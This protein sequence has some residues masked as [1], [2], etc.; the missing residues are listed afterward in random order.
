MPPKKVSPVVRNCRGKIS[1]FQKSIQSSLDS[2]QEL[3]KK[4]A[5]SPE[6]ISK[7]SAV[8][9]YLESDVKAY[10]DACVK[11]ASILD[12]STVESSDEAE[13]DALLEFLFEAREV[14][15]KV[16]F[17]TQALP[18]QTSPDS[19]PSESERLTAE[20]CCQMKDLLSIHKD[21][22]MHTRSLLDQQM[23][24]SAQT[25]HRSTVNLP[26]LTIP[27]F[28]G[29]ILK[30]AEFQDM[31]KSSVEDHHG[32]SDVQKF[33]YLREH[34]SGVAYETIA[35]LSVTESN[36]KIALGLLVERFGDKQVQ[37]NA[38][39]ISL[40]DLPPSSNKTT[41]L[42]KFYDAVETHL[43]SLTA[44]DEDV[45]QI[46]YVS[47]ITSKISR[48]TMAQLE[49]QKGTGPWSVTNLRSKLQAYISAQEAAE[50]HS[51]NQVMPEKAP[52]PRA[53][54]LQSNPA[55][56]S[57]LLTTESRSAANPSP[58]SVQCAFCQ[59]P[60]YSDECNKY[61][62][63]D[64]RKP[65]VGNRCFRCLR[66][67]HTVHT[68]R[69]NKPCFYCRR[70]DHHSSLCPSKFSSRVRPEAKPFQPSPAVNALAGEDK[71]VVMQ[72]AVVQVIS[73]DNP[74][75]TTSARILFDTGSCRS[76][77][78]QSLQA[79]AKLQ[80]L[81]QDSIALA[82]FGSTSR[83]TTNYPRVEVNI[84]Q[85]D[86]T[87][88][89]ISANVIP[90]ITAPIR[91]VS[92]NTC[93][94]PSLRQLP[95][96]EPLDSTSDR[97]EIDILIGLDHYYKIIG[98][99]RISFP[100]GLQ[101]LHSSV[102][103]VC[104][105]T[106]DA[107]PISPVQ[108]RNTALVV[109]PHRPS[110][111]GLD[112]ERFW[113]VED[114]GIS[115]SNEQNEDRLAYD[116]FLQSI[117]F[118][119]NRY[120]V[121]WPW[122]EPHR[123]LENNYS[124]AFGRLKSLMK[125][126]LRDPSTLTK[127]NNVLEEQQSLGIL[128][129]VNS[130]T[131][132]MSR[133]HYLPHHCVVKPSNNTTKVRIVYDASA[134]VSK[135]S[136]S[137]NDCLYA[138]PTLLP[139]LCGIL[140][141]FRL[142]PI[143]ICSD[144]EKAFLQLTL[145][146]QDRDV[147]RFLWLKNINQPVTVD[148]LQTFRFCRVPFGI[149]SS[150]FLL[151]ATLKHHLTSEKTADAD[152]VLQNTYVDNIIL[153]KASVYDAVAHYRSA[154]SILASASMNLREWSSNS[155][156]VLSEIPA[157]DKSDATKQKCLGL[158][159]DTKQDTL[160][161]SPPNSGSHVVTSKRQVLQALSRFFD[162]LG[163]KAP[164]AIRAKILMQEI[165]KLDVSWDETLSPDMLRRWQQIANDLDASSNTPV[166]RYIGLPAGNTQVYQLHVFCDASAAAYA[167]VA[168]LQSTRGDFSVTNL[169]FSKVRVAPVKVQT[170]PRLELMAAA[171]GSRV[172]TF[173][174]EHLPIR[175]LTTYLYSDSTTVLHW[176]KSDNLP[177]FVQNR[178]N[179]IQSV[180]DVTYQYVSTRDNP[181]DLPSRGVT[182]SSLSASKL[183]WHGP[184]LPVKSKGDASVHVAAGE[185][186][187]EGSSKGSGGQGI[188]HNS[189]ANKKSEAPP[190]GMN[191]EN[192]SS[193]D[194]L[195]RVS[196]FCFRFVSRLK[197]SKSFSGR[198]HPDEL[199]AAEAVWIQ[200]SQAAHY[201]D[202]IKALKH[203]K[204]HPLIAKLDPVLDEGLIRCRG[205]MTNADLCFNAR[206]P[207]LVPR[208]HGI[209]NLIVMDCHRK[210]MHAGVA[211]T[212]SRI[213]FKYWI[214]KG[215]AVVNSRPLTYVDDDQVV[216]LT[217]ASF[218]N[219]CGST[220]FLV[221]PDATDPDFRPIQTST[222]SLLDLWK[223]GQ[224]RLD[225]F[226]KSW[227]DDYLLSLRETHTV[228]LRQRRILAPTSPAVGDV[229]L[230]KEDLPRANWRLGK[231]QEIHTSADDQVRSATVLTADRRLLKRPVSLLY[232]IEIQQ[233]TVQSKTNEDPVASPPT[234]SDRPSRAAAN[235]SRSR[236]RELI[237]CG[238]V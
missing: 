185:G 78:S 6:D 94:H 203:G 210:V 147:T 11:L 217:P 163:L 118:D 134:K 95:L 161:I 212:L 31:Y 99:D 51:P 104:A 177:V 233:D 208:Q 100:D 109:E 106:V 131:T 57:A 123:H 213:R 77:V 183:W 22:Q 63:V 86:S 156:E 202:E 173:L 144:I 188:G 21:T 75:S 166:P 7:L 64:T 29:D 72:T 35:G 219:S 39:H 181:A 97:L 68:C 178:V 205:R 174:R 85:N 81:G 175:I 83:N 42:R 53:P 87:L 122:R 171:L 227:K 228:N 159:W 67:G 198:L 182:A 19:K 140:L 4:D 164:V 170:I 218:V 167:A 236:L 226:W 30:W 158:V 126:L 41:S 132:G 61:T 46:I 10:D 38:L 45:E 172:I 189:Q 231:I 60:H 50:R 112:L 25:N 33:T 111:P 89:L 88:L 223:K 220:G 195:V 103:F 133:V 129:P 32:L 149:V 65:Q 211:H 16:K 148:N 91:R 84:K 192:F 110:D 44:L 139:D 190:F 162:P 27:T 169:I 152:E 98:T 186:P 120:V 52:P 199:Q 54:Q 17:A 215:R 235:A 153:S 40:M 157:R 117:T 71:S 107:T 232:P 206:F 62:T 24:A 121:S 56:S 69:A 115:D 8:H 49:L 9:T 37:I 214:P 216:T 124:L 230:I 55:R 12:P 74:N 146:P 119:D 5:L 209:A 13:S 142:Q 221:L 128:E 28:T 102:G 79:Q 73:P 20:L 191:V 47:L 66:F 127:Y 201:G 14:L 114:I 207:V 180:T 224:R 18:R 193:F 136:P 200:H 179:S 101:L 76:Y 237:D 36:Y 141:R 196:A 184:S 130:I 59:G 222:S 138:G 92:L 116:N 2:A 145:H 155:P 34:L 1:R 229:V 168:Y 143:A 82:T 93:T 70:S 194:S 187:S 238:N 204:N 176:L 151:S 105:G 150:P 135:S 113:A 48:H 3:F 234:R 225:Q 26:K 160:S 137:L 58:K 96:A 15:K 197:K 165:W 23:T 90:K 154:K 125:R 108:E 43:R 80:C